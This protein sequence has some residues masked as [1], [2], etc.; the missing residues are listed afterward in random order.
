MSKLLNWLMVLPF[1]LIWRMVIGITKLPTSEPIEILTV[2]IFLVVSYAG[3]A[4]KN[5]TIG[6]IVGGLL[7]VYLLIKGR[8]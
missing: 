5:Y 3:I 6:L 2:L 8:K 1:Q 7:G 4:T